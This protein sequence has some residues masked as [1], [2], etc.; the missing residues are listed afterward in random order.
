MYLG[1]AGISKQGEVWFEI[2]IHLVSKTIPVMILN[3]DAFSDGNTSPCIESI[4]ARFICVNIILPQIITE[5]GLQLNVNR[6][7]ILNR[8]CLTTAHKEGDKQLDQ[9]CI[10]YMLVGK[11]A[12]ASY[13]LHL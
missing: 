9:L 3:K 4:A 8:W 10:G 6:L 7:V 11:N 13:R 2:V 1:V 5:V 12:L